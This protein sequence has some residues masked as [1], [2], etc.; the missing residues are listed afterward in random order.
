MGF[1]KGWYS[2][3]SCRK[4]LGIGYSNSF[5]WKKQKWDQS[6]PC[7]NKWLVTRTIRTFLWVVIHFWMP[8]R[9]FSD[10]KW[11]LWQRAI[12]HGFEI[13]SHDVF[14]C[15]A[16]S[17]WEDLLHIR[18]GTWKSLLGKTEGRDYASV[19]NWS[20]HF[21]SREILCVHRSKI[22]AVSVGPG[23]KTLS[24][25]IRCLYSNVND[26]L[27]GATSQPMK[28]VVNRCSVSIPVN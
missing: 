15:I 22:L 28:T 5:C 26:C 2:A 17:H 11:F 8:E 27:F 18:I 12:E 9:L 21:E 24:E 14:F 13:L 10:S 25:W 16:G 20:E 7:Q 6:T 19:G 3:S 23:Y 4:R 1:C